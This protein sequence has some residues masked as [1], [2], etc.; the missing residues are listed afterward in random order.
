M[1]SSRLHRAGLAA[2]VLLASAAAAA[3]Q[4]TGHPRCDALV[5]QRVLADDLGYQIRCD[6]DFP[7]TS[8]TG[9]AI[10]GWA[11]HDERILWLWP[12]R[13]TDTRVLRKIAWHELGHVVWDRQ[14]RTGTQADEERW[15]DGFSWCQEQLAGVGYTYR[16][17][18][19]A[20][21]RRW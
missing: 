14:G 19:C 10:V 17:T 2:L 20:E 3:C 4:P 13:M 21:F 11:E 7:G 12:D 8:P 5:A 16:P 9:R 15:A 6:P 1:P 18:N